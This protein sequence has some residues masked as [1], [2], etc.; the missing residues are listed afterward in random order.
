M[1]PTVIL[2]VIDR[3]INPHYPHLGA[4]PDTLIKCTCCVGEG[5]VEIKCPFSGREYRPDQLNKLKNS[6]L[7]AN[8]LLS[9]E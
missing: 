9:V 4:S 5:I 1:N 7:D 3:N 2:N 8:G 6:F